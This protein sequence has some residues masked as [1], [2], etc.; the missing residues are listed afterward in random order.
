M[1]T[2]L[3]LSLALPLSTLTSANA[4][5]ATAPVSSARTVVAV[6]AGTIHVVAGGTV[7]EGGGTILIEDGRIVAVGKDIDIPPSA[8]T[9]DYGPDAVIAP[10]L[11]AADSTYGNPRGSERSADPGVRA[12]DQFDPYASFVLALEEG[13]TSAYIAPARGRLIAGQG[14]V[15]KLGG[16]DDRQRVLNDSAVI[17]GAISAEARNTPGYWQPPVPATVDVGMGVEQSQLPRTLLG[18]VV[19]LKELLTLAQGGPDDGTY[20]PGVGAQLR[21]LMLAHKPWRIAATNPAEIRALLAFAQENNLPVIIDGANGAGSLAAEIAKA[22][23]SVIVD[24]PV[25][26][27]GQGRD[28]GKARDAQRPEYDTAALLARAGVKF[29]IAPGNAVAASDLRFAASVASRGGLDREVALRAITLAPAEILGVANR[30]GSLEAGKDADLAIFNGPPLDVTSGVI[31]TWVDG[32][33][34]FKAY[35]T[36]AVVVAVDELH[37][38]N[39]EIMAPGEILMRDGRIQDVGRRVGHPVGATVVHGKA[40]MPGMIDALGHLGLEG[41]T[42]VPATRF[43][44]K[45]LVEPGDFADR[46][47]AQAGVTTVVLSPRGANRSGAP[48]MAYKPAD[49]DFEKMVIRDPVALRF[50]WTEHNRL[51]SGKSVR[52]ILS[53]AVEYDKKWEDYGKKLE[54]FKSSK[55]GKAAIEQAAKKDGDATKKD[56]DGEKKEGSDADKKAEGDKKEGVE[57]KKGEEK[58]KDEEGDKKK[59]AKKKKGEEELARPVTGSWETK[60]TV[61][62]MAESRMRLYLLDE[63]GKVKGSL[64]CAALSEDLIEVSGKREQ[65]KLSLSGEGSRG[66]ITIDADETDGKLEGKLVLGDTKVDFKAAQ[67]STEYEVAGRSERRKPKEEKKQE[68]KGEPKSPGVDPDLEPL[69]RAMYGEGAVIVGV[70]RE[71]EIKACVEAFDDANIKP[72][73]LGANDA[74]K[75]IDQIRGKVAGVLLNQKIVDVDPKTGAQKR[76][77]YAE[78]ANAGIPVA[79]HSSAEEGAVDLPLMAEYAVSQ[80]MSPQGALRALTIDAAHMFAIDDRVGTIAVGRDADVLLLDGSPLEASTSV[81]R[82]WVNGKEVR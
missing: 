48:M 20:G 77:R 1:N 54:A 65:R 22:G 30:V 45:R 82:V 75:V 80:G 43:E 61:P 76:N 42:K 58:K 33:I 17:H 55:E 21:E 50:Q 23:V 53:K 69:R 39:G 3:S 24:S 74:Y 25:N 62:P 12:I 56:G 52:E 73:L 2:L 67:T 7:I 51:E 13:V 6:K 41:S 26:P 35:E 40:A 28:F 19:A 66:K 63:D 36:S 15:V 81:T 31:A 34:A 78:L 14:A 9:V 38:G 49:D 57:E 27:N 10:G 47:V 8:R 29:A 18:A 44:L 70:D 59:P 11:V 32:E 4:S 16:T 37:I 5:L 60:I 64:R 72:V 46:R 68:I 79:F 71:D